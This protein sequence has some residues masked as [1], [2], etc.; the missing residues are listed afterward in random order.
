MKEFLHTFF[1]TSEERIKNPIIGSFLTSWI[2]FNWKPLLFFIFTQKTIED[3][4]IYIEGNYTNIWNLLLLPLIST[5]IYLII[6]PYINL[7]IEI[8]LNYSQSKRSDLSI[9]KQKLTIESQKQLAIEE[10]KLEEAKTQFRERN[11]HNKLVEELQEKIVILE[12]EKVSEFEKSKEHIESLKIEMNKREKSFK[13]ELLNLEKKYSN[14]LHKVSELNSI[15]R[16]HEQELQSQRINLNESS[17]ENNIIRE[18]V[19]N[20]GRIIQQKN[21]KNGDIYYIDKN[22]RE[23]LTENKVER[24]MNNSNVLE[25]IRFSK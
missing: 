12:T 16:K 2:I 6:L 21:N 9:K 13:N 3:K 19:L 25:E 10:I 22:T 18:F 1:K 24:I 20:N 11:N 7:G 17:K 15:I 23:T 5:F 4:I 8:L 14:S